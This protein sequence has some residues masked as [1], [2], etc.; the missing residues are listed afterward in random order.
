MS[1]MKA[2]KVGLP[3]NSVGLGGIGPEVIISKLGLP[4]N[5]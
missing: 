2:A 4:G 3:I 1:S 5:F